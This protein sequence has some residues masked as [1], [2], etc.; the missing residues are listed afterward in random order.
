VI[1]KAIPGEL[2]LIPIAIGTA[3]AFIGNAKL[4]CKVDLGL[5]TNCK[6]VSVL[7][8]KNCQLFLGRYIANI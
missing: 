6:F 8:T 5:K 1:A 3:S 7:T 4:N 2:L